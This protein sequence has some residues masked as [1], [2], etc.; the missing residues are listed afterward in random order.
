MGSSLQDG[1]LLEEARSYAPAT[2]YEAAGAIGGLPPEIKPVDPSFV[3]C[4][5][6]LPVSTPP[7]DNLWIHRAIASAGPHDVLVVSTGGAYQAGY[8]GEVLST[9]AAACGL[10]GA[11]IDGC[12][13]DGARL[14][15]VGVPVFARG[16]C[17]FATRKDPDGAGSIGQPVRVGDTTVEAGDVVI[18]DADGVV[19]IRR[20]DFGTVL[21]SAVEREAKEAAAF[22]RLKRGETTMS[23]YGFGGQ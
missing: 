10:E 5:W 14:P 3:V 4:G 18:G 1:A 12:V 20:R 15:T 11:V 21:R 19:V 6:A 23:I 7:H 16:L 13:R 9:A 22:Q 2:F 17:M 8:W